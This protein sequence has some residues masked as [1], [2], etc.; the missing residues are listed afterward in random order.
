MLKIIPNT[1]STRTCMLSSFGSSHQNVD[2]CQCKYW[3][4]EIGSYVECRLSKVLQD[5]QLFRAN[6]SFGLI[7]N[8][9]KELLCLHKHDS[10]FIKCAISIC[11][12]TIFQMFQVLDAYSLE[13][14]KKFLLF[15]TGSD[16]VPVGGMGE[17]TFK[18]TK[19]TQKLKNGESKQKLVNLPEAHTCFNQL[20]LPGIIIN[21]VI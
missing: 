4:H 20:V 10:A 18:I 1:F 12:K 2:T 8:Q 13:L 17:M 16:R 11:C 14:Q 9:Q 19:M 5:K 15:T 7:N 6:I 21:D 3:Y